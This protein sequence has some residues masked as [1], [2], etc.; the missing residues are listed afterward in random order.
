MKYINQC[1]NQH[2]YN[3]IAIE[4]ST[5]HPKLTQATTLTRKICRPSADILHSRPPKTAQTQ[6]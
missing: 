5:L 4:Q 3:S 1:K 6:P 2:I